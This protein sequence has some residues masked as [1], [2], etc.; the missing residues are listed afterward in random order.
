MNIEYSA[1]GNIAIYCG[2]KFR[3]DPKSGYYLCTKKTDAGHRERLH[4][5]VWRKNNGGIPDGYHV[6]HI[7]GDKRNNDIGNLACIPGEQHIR[8]HSKKRVVTEYEYICKNLKEN[9]APKAAEWHKSKVGRQ[10]HSEQAK[11]TFESLTEKRYICE[12]CGK[13]FFKK[14]FSTSKYCSNAC[15]TKARAKSGVDNEERACQVCGRKY[16][17]NKYSK[18]KTCSKE[19]GHILCWDKRHQAAG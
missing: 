15:K 3:R 17:A 10:W 13:E 11:K 4:V 1:D 18:V 7:D 14:S 5:F 6:H 16:I 19:C 9:A 12:F 8:Q 2:Y